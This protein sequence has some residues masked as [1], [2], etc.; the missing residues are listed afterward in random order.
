MTIHVQVFMCTY[1][2]V[3][4]GYKPK[5]R[6]SGSYSNSMFN[7]LNNCKEFSKAAPTFCISTS[8]M[9]GFKFFYIFANTFYHHFYFS[10]C[11]RQQVVAYSFDLHLHN[12]QWFWVALCLMVIYITYIKKGIFKFFSYWLIQ[13]FVFLLLNYEFFVY[14]VY[15]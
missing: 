15:K 14:S 2:F 8:N 3:S 1:V 11:N 9:W 10:H 5:S 6:I 12:V 7:I 13:L 4:F